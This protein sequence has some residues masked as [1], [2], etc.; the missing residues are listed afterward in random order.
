MDDENDM[1]MDKD[2]LRNTVDELF[3]M[4]IYDQIEGI[5]LQYKDIA[6]YDNDLSTV[7]HLLYI[8]KMEKEAGQKTILEKTG[9]ISA[10]LERFTILKLYLRRFDFNCIG[11]SLQDFYQYVVQNNVS[12]YE[13]LTVADYSVVHKKEVLEAIQELLQKIA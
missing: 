6:T 10:L 2:K 11:E 13:L 8:Y 12:A 5:L 4:R 9:S 7:Y 3:R 1:N